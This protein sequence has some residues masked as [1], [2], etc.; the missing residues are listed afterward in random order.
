MARSFTGSV[1]PRR[2]TDGHT[3][4]VLVFGGDEWKSFGGDVRFIGSG[5]VLA[6]GF[7]STTCPS[8]K[9]DEFNQ[10]IILSQAVSLRFFLNEEPEDAVT[11]VGTGKRFYGV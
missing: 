3:T 5:T 11:S 10:R 7:Y 4:G 1:S 8:S 2:M 6:A 9:A